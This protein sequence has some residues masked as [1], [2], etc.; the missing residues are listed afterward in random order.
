[1]KRKGVVVVIVVRGFLYS[2]AGSWMMPKDCVCMG[3]RILSDLHQRQKWHCR[4]EKGGRRGVRVLRTT[5]L[6]DS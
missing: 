3:E 5:D 1:M 2:C 4:G 6:V